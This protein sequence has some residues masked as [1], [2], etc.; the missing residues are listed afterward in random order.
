MGDG[1]V[2]AVICRDET[3]TYAAYKQQSCNVLLFLFLKKKKKEHTMKLIIALLQ[4]ITERF[5]A[6]KGKRT[7]MKNVSCLLDE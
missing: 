3:P 1:V 6:L 2:T 7:Q 4:Q 5:G